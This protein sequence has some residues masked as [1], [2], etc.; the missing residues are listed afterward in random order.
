MKKCGVG[1]L[2][3]F[4]AFLIGC[5]SVIY[6]TIMMYHRSNDNVMVF[7]YI[8][9]DNIN[10][11][12]LWNSSR[13][14]WVQKCQSTE[15]MFVVDVHKY[16]AVT[17]SAPTIGGNGPKWE[18]APSV[19]YY[20]KEKCMEGY[21]LKKHETVKPSECI[22]CSNV[23]DDAL[24]AFVRNGL[25]PIDND[26]TTQT[27]PCTAGKTNF[28]DASGLFK[29]M[30]YDDDPDSPPSKVHIAKSGS[31]VAI[32]AAFVVF[33]IVAMVAW[34]A[35]FAPNVGTLPLLLRAKFVVPLCLILATGLYFWQDHT[36]RQL[37]A[38]N[39]SGHDGKNL[40]Q[41]TKFSVLDNSHRSVTCD[42]PKDADGN[43]ESLKAPL[44]LVE[45]NA[46]DNF[47]NTFV[48]KSAESGDET[49]YSVNSRANMEVPEVSND[50]PAS[51]HFIVAYTGIM[52]LMVCNGVQK[53]VV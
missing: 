32:R 27:N 12:Y 19:T 52:L 9:D 16:P 40:L 47:L 2:L 10:S 45:F 50:T 48:K 25:I 7:A 21:K 42:S 36:M 4:A 24:L 46:W 37:D 22:K 49:P 31:V 15:Q 1:Q 28:N 5:A 51:P 44:T 34:L 26:F 38:V 3:F 33:V 18:E 23:N 13:K 43:Q 20:A 14:D 30:P 35:S 41:W 17:V 6:G 39:H 8:P 53:L 11:T 29:R